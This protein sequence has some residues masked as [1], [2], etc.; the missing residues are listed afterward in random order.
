MCDNL[1]SLDNLKRNR[2][3]EKISNNFE[4]LSD[5]VKE[6][7]LNEGVEEIKILKT[8]EMILEFNRQQQGK[9]LKY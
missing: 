6:L 3:A 7:A 8:V 1:F 4:Y 9:G 2:V 5:K